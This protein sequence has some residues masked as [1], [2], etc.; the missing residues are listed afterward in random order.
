MTEQ[1]EA[2][3]AYPAASPAPEPNDKVLVPSAGEVALA[4]EA[5]LE[6]FHCPPPAAAP[7]PVAG[8]TFDL[9]ELEAPESTIT[10][11][12]DRPDP[13]GE[14]LEEFHGGPVEPAV[15]TFNNEVAPAVEGGCEDGVAYIFDKA[16]NTFERF[17]DGGLIKGNNAGPVIKPGHPQ[18]K[19]NNPKAAFGAAKVGI[20]YLSFPVLLEQAVG[21]MAGGYKYGAHNYLT[22]PPSVMTYVA[23]GFRH[24]AAFVG[25]EEFD[26]HAGDGVKVHHLVA[27]QNCLHVVRAA[28]IN[29]NFFDDRPPAMPPGFIESLASSIEALQRNNPE[30]VARYLADGK[31]GPG[32]IL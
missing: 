7:W 4:E 31:R 2:P 32:R 11:P 25:G 21:M 30:P 20:D 24:I 12:L 9:N 19:D 15:Q 16:S 22:I 13:I 26:P 6:A 3:Q 28:M 29:G 5:A 8:S 23:A 17:S 27:A 10:Q 18:W 14:A 1:F